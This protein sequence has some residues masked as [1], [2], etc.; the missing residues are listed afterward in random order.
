MTSWLKITQIILFTPYFLSLRS[1]SEMHRHDQHL[2][3][4]DNF[5][6]QVCKSKKKKPKS[7]SPK[8]FFISIVSF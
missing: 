4:S 2:L 8:H 7:A 5:S 6:E 3:S 1:Q